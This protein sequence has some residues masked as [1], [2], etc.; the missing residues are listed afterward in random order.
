MSRYR[1]ARV[2]G[3]V[4]F[5]TLVTF[6]R[7]PFLV[8]PESRRLLRQAWQLTHAE[9]PFESLALVLLPDHMHCLWQLPEGD[10]DF[11]TRWRLIKGRFTVGYAGAGH[12]L[13]RPSPSRARVG[14]QTVWQ[15]RF[16]EHLIRDQEDLKR[17]VDYIHY[18]P[19]KH[20]HA[21][22]AADWPY[23][24]FPKYVRLG[25]YSPAWGTVEPESLRGWEPDVE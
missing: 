10:G 5:F 15:R 18:N 21:Q 4:Y 8:E 19:V 6:D 14:E 12:G 20:G 2:S 3:A 16:W 22:R 13:P 9:R 17:H 1:R 25:Q 23:S 24:T 11:S 7:R